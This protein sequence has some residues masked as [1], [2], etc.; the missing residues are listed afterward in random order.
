MSALDGSGI[1]DKDR[2]TEASADKSAKSGQR[3][4]LQE[5]MRPGWRRWKLAA[6]ELALASIAVIRPSFAL[7]PLTRRWRRWKLAA[8]ERALAGA[9]AIRVGF[10]LRPLI[11]PYWRRWKLTTREMA[12]AGIAVICAGFAGASFAL[13]HEI[14]DSP[15]CAPSLAA[16][17]RQIERDSGGALALPSIL[18]AFRQ[19]SRQATPMQVGNLGTRSD[20]NAA[21]ANGSPSPSSPEAAVDRAHP[22]SRGSGAQSAAPAITPAQASS[23]ASQTAP[24]WDVSVRPDGTLIAPV[25]SPNGWKGSPVLEEASKP[26]AKPTPTASPPTDPAQAS[27]PKV[28]STKNPMPLQ[29]PAAAE[30][31]A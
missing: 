28:D 21:P 24:V 11:R 7:R 29:K 3:T 14:Q 10:D 5:S 23:G 22:A 16:T 25:S 8:R 26:D 12:L 2:P 20:A 27:P 18:N 31:V 4:D 30:P 15:Q 9:A 1:G 6:R 13:R 17:E 19:D